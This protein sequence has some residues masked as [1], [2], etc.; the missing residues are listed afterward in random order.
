M[1]QL[2]SYTGVD[3]YMP[4]PE[5]AL[6]D[7]A[8]FE[9]SVLCVDLETTSGHPKKH[10]KFV[11]EGKCGI[12]GIALTCAGA[13]RAWYVPIEHNACPV[14]NYN[15][16]TALAWLADV[17]RRGA[18]W[19]NAN[20]KYDIHALT[21][22]GL[23][24]VELI[25]AYDVI[26]L[27]KLVDS[28]RQYK[29]GYGLTALVAWLF[30]RDIRPYESRLKQAL[31][32]ARPKGAK[33]SLDYGDAS[34]QVLGPYA[35]VD[36]IETV[37][38]W[39]ELRK[40]LP[41][42]SSKVEETERMVTKELVY[43][44][45]G[46][47]LY[48]RAECA[49]QVVG[50]VG[51][52]QELIL[53]IARASNGFINPTSRRDVEDYLI[54]QCGLP[55]VD[56]PSA[57]FDTETAEGLA[58]EDS[59]W[60][61]K[62]DKHTLPEYAALPGAPVQVI[63]DILEYRASFK[64]LTAF[65]KVFADAA[66]ER[67]F[68]HGSYNQAVRTGR[69]SCSRPNNMQFSD[70][71][72]ALI[73]PPP[74]FSIF[75]SDESQIEYR[76]LGHYTGEPIILQAYAADPDTD[77]HSKMAAIAKCDRRFSKVVNFLSAYGGGKKKLRLQLASNKHFR[78]FAEESFNGTDFEAHLSRLVDNIYDAYHR[79]FPSLKR[80]SKNMAQRAWDKGYVINLYGRVRRLAQTI[81][82]KKYS[83]TKDALNTLCQ[84]TAADIVKEI[85]AF[86]L[87]AAIRKLGGWVFAQVHDEIAGYIPTE[88]ARDPRF[89][90]DLVYAMEA[91]PQRLLKP[92][93]V[94]L[95]STY[96]ISE[97]SWQEASEQKLAINH[98]EVRPGGLF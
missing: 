71:A 29:G 27:A 61:P 39:Q 35:C 30:D 24:P 44:E 3:C 69:L 42:V 43:M 49:A 67:N 81:P 16:A 20:V 28:D 58:E 88:I 45:R 92:L 47:M 9:G 25:P 13:N 68:L 26:T 94:P 98:S 14:F 10:T 12:A 97:V 83:P 37:A 4:L 41:Q 63:S 65:L 22:N 55:Y 76:L 95:R 86:R 93:R 80:E 56:E 51:R 48:D 87:C 23:D 84:G 73:V 72:K 53:Q 82:G 79:G 5:D 78:K 19:V 21:R 17:L 54:T 64:F 75:T 2:D 62:F 66:D 50:A 91:P 90:A 40:R 34:P 32:D 96:G 31:V 46:G 52:Q 70:R 60:S 36:V 18:L 89:A 1:I 59:D 85:M 57:E 38:C 33:T 15:K 11:Y 7:P 77:F 6:P 74:G 8:L